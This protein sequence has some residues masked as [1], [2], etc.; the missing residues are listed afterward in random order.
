MRK[1]HRDN[2]AIERSGDSLD[3]R[4]QPLKTGVNASER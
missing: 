3:N 4:P 1:P 2:R